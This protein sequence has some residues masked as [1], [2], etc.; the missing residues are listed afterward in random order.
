[1]SRFLTSLYILLA[2]TLPQANAQQ[3]KTTSIPIHNAQALVLIGTPGYPIDGIYHLANDIDMRQL[4]TQ[5]LQ[6]GCLPIGGRS[7]AIFNGQLDGRG[8]TIRHL[9]IH[10]PQQDGV[11]LFYGVGQ[12]ACVENVCLENVKVQGRNNVGIIAGYNYGCI[13]KI[14]L[15]AKSLLIIKGNKYVGSVVGTNKGRIS[16]IRTAG[17]VRG[18][19]MVGGLAGENHGNISE[20]R[21]QSTVT[22]YKSTG[23]LVG[24]NKG[25]INKIEP[26]S[27]VT[28]YAMVGGLVGENS[29][30]ISKVRA[31]S[32]VTGYEL[33]GGLVGK[34]KGKITQ[35]TIAGK[36]TG[37]LKVNSLAGENHGTTTFYLSWRV[38]KFQLA[39]NSNKVLSLKPPQKAI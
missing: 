9:R 20:I 5:Q 35:C 22:G 12:E 1:M 33:I 24:K 17:N 10:K 4:T 38:K 27:T 13:K 36:V 30:R 25:K 7:Q 21:I 28:G 8:K 32:T 39:P 26:Q 16:E 31:Q 11:G 37:V 2:L 23:G 15:K 34:N 19:T 6:Q 18:H 3:T 29:G 14:E